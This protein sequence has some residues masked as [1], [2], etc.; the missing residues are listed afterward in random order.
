VAF[1]GW[2]DSFKFL[3]LVS[4]SERPDVAL[5]TPQTPLTRL[6]TL[7]VSSRIPAV[8]ERL[9]LWRWNM[10]TW[11]LDDVTA[12][13]TGASNGAIQIAP[14]R[15]AGDSGAPVLDR[16]GRVVGM[17][18]TENSLVDGPSILKVLQASNGRPICFC[19]RKR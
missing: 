2:Y 11:S 5:W 4:R 7:E 12:T 17:V 8:G 9:T 19:K 10:N 13:V 14:R 6:E 16:F 15:D 3:H 18:I 1:S